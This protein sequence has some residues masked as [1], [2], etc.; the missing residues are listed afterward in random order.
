MKKIMFYK[1]FGFW[2]SICIIIIVIGFYTTLLIYLDAIKDESIGSSIRL[3]IICLLMYGMFS[4]IP[5]LIIGRYLEQREEKEKL[6]E[7]K[8]YNIKFMKNKL[9]K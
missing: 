3:G 5:W 2:A 1:W 9:D 4:M 7:K 6:T 8:E